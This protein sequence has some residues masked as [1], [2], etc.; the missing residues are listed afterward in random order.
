VTCLIWIKTATR[1][2]CQ[3]TSEHVTFPHSYHTIWHF[4]K[5]QWQSSSNLDYFF[6]SMISGIVPDYYWGIWG[7]FYKYYTFK[8]HHQRVNWSSW[9]V[10]RV[11]WHTDLE[12]LFRVTIFIYP[13][14]ETWEQS[15]TILNPQRTG[16]V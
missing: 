5:L 10:S 12:R 2:L 4:R 3:L 14:P 11:W 6:T 9:R 7:Y 13:L 16:D 8:S 15:G 1:L